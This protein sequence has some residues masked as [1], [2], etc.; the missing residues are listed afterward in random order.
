MIDIHCEGEALCD[1]MSSPVATREMFE[2]LVQHRP[3]AA[4]S[5][6]WKKLLELR[7][8]Q[9]IA[10]R[11]WRKGFVHLTVDGDGM[12]SLW[13]DKICNK[14]GTPVDSYLRL[15][16]TADQQ[17]QISETMKKGGHTP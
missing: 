7:E 6:C 14:D 2:M 15:E 16:L 9:S 13:D 10:D 17:Y 1:K 3:D 8:H 12:V 11:T 5:S 4:C